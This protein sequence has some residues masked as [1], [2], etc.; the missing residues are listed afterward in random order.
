ME[1]NKIFVAVGKEIEERKSTL[2]WALKKSKGETIYVIYVHVP[3]QIIHLPSNYN[4]HGA[5][6]I[7]VS[8]FPSCARIF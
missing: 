6:T 8:C 1:E 2:K 5:F 7:V 3:A 4:V